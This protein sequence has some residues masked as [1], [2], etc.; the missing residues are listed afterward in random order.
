ML[1]GFRWASQ[2]Q[3]PQQ[4]PSKWLQS[5]PAAAMCISLCF[6]LKAICLMSR[7]LHNLWVRCGRAAV[8]LALLPPCDHE[9]LQYPPFQQGL[10]VQHSCDAVRQTPPLRHMYYNNNNN[11]N[12]TSLYWNVPE[13]SSSLEMKKYLRYLQLWKQ[14]LLFIQFKKLISKR[15]TCHVI[16]SMHIYR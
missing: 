5:A 8:L 16:V 10:I 6:Q 2:K 7:L 15:H 13:T 11:N 1:H 3:Q 12:N 4:K 9:T 14:M